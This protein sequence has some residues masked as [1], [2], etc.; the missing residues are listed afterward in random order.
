MRPKKRDPWKSVFL[1][2]KFGGD[3]LHPQIHAALELPL[4]SE[5]A[6][7]DSGNLFECPNFEATCVI[8][9][10]ELRINNLVHC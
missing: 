8:D 6:T 1:E 7:S 10:V 2:K 4:R 3:A 9:G 5:F